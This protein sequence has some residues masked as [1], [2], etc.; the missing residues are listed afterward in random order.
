MAQLPISKVASAPPALEAD[1]R[2]ELLAQDGL[3]FSSL[4]VRRV[5]DGVCLEGVLELDDE[6]ADVTAAALRIDGVTNVQNHLHV[7]NA[8]VEMPQKGKTPRLPR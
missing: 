8:D 1:V 4:V 6:N 2:R 3:R 5:A 7:R